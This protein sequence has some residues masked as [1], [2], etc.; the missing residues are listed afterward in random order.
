MKLDKRVWKWNKEVYVYSI[1]I[2][3]DHEAPGASLASA[4]AKL[5]RDFP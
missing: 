5:P 1:D 3:D 2:P 4:T